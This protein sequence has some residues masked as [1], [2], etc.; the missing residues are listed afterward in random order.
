MVVNHVWVR[1]WKETVMD[2]FKVLFWNMV[3]FCKKNLEQL[4]IADSLTLKL[5]LV[6]S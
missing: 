1:I 6:T 5:Q 2:Y 3:S 4:G